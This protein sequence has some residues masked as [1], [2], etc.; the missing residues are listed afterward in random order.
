MA[1]Q[2]S[3]LSNEHNQILD[4]KDYM[5]LSAQPAMAKPND[6]RVQSTRTTLTPCPATP[7]PTTTAG[8]C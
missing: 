6:N 7:P 3:R 5:S 2:A 1:L 8:I 4:D